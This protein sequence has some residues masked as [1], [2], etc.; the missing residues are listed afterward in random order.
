MFKVE[1]QVYT[2]HSLR[3]QILC[4]KGPIQITCSTFLPK[5]DLTDGKDKAV[6]I[7][8]VPQVPAAQYP[9]YNRF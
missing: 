5:S 3:H 4:W 9:P 6:I 8:G 2:F 7:S 1:V